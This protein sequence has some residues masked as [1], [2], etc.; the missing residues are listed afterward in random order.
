MDRWDDDETQGWGLDAN[1]D[2]LNAVE[3]GLPALRAYTREV[4]ETEPT[5][6]EI[7]EQLDEAERQALLV[8]GADA[9]TDAEAAVRQLRTLL[10]VGAAYLVAA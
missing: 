1:A 2:L 6:G 5:L 3:A 4:V 10:R 9:Q 8:P 7:L